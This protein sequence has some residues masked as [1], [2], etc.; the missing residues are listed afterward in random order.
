ME[1]QREKTKAP[2]AVNA[3]QIIQRIS[4]CN[5]EGAEEKQ[6]GNARGEERR[7]RERQRRGRKTERSCAERRGEERRSVERRGEGVA[8]RSR[9]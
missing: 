6:E 2:K 9:G 8:Q 3:A 5:N 1:T 7:Q 4:Q